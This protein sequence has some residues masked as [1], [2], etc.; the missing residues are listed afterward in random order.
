MLVS[1]AN[2][3][4][5]VLTLNMEMG[6]LVRDGPLPGQVKVHLDRLCQRQL[7]MLISDN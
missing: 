6:I 5:Y 7:E 3:T 1:S 2:L 4:E